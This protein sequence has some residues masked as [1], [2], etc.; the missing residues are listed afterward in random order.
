LRSTINE[1]FRV[2]YRPPPGSAGA[3]PAA[4]AL[5]PQARGFVFVSETEIFGRQRPR[6]PELHRRA[7]ATPSQIDQ[8]LDFS[9]LVEGDFV[10]HIQHGIAVFRGLT[11]LETAAGTREVISLEFDDKVTLHVPLQEAH[12]VSRYVGLAKARPQLGRVG[13]GRWE[14]TRAAAEHAT[15]DLAAQLLEV[16]ARRAAQ[17]GCAFEPDTAWQRA[18]EASFPFAETP[19]QLRAISETKNDMEQTRPMDRL[20]C[21]DV[22]FGKTEVAIRAAFKAVMSGRQV[23]VLVPTTVLAQQHFNTFCERMGGYPVAIEMLS[24]FRSPREQR[25]I[26]AATVKGEVDI[27][28]GT[29]RLIQRDVAFKDL[30]L[31]VVDEEQRFGVRHKEVFKQWRAHVDVLSMSATPIPRTLYLALTGARD[32]SVIESAPADRHPIQTIVKTYDEAL[33]IAAIRHE[34]RRGGQVFYLHNRVLTIDAVAQ[35]LRELLPDLSIAVGHGQM[36]ED[37]LERIMTEFVA[38]RHHVLV[39][40]TIIESGLDIPNCNTILIEGADR[41][42]LSQLYQ[43]RGRVGRFKHQ[44]YACT[45]ILA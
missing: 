36:G 24:R 25:R 26:L 1:G 38:G 12:L 37:D 28:I 31:V 34:T 35:R 29:H 23:A 39:C 10:V 40:T 32:L 13:T 15:L 41:F 5:A 8:L 43:L 27:L 2:T 3:G 14:K 45:A 44:A 7:V 9:E 16:Q 42:G 17:P 22:G 20:V 11:R 30:G 19:D 6:R 21:G 18:F 33:V 4:L